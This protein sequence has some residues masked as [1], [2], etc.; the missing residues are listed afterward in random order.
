M[1]PTDKL[2]VAEQLLND[3]KYEEAYTAY[4]SLAEL[5]LLD[6]QIMMGWMKEYGRGT[7]H[8]FR[9][10]LDWYQKAAS[11]GSPTAQFHVGRILM[12]TGDPSEAL[13]WFE[14]AANSEY[15]PAVYRLAWAFESGTGTPVDKDHACT[16]FNQSASKGHLPSQM[17]LAK[18]VL[19]G[20]Q[21]NFM[22]LWGAYNVLKTYMKTVLVAWKNM[23]DDRVRI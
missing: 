20:S 16:L 19:R 23:R 1:D 5:G 10:A 14:K 3:E 2:K 7:S 21:G 15:M 18:K 8:D 22:R 6:A 13:R 17:V 4:S 11:M 9:G 12:Q